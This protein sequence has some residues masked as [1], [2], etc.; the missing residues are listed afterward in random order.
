[1]LITLFLLAAVILA[2]SVV[3]RPRKTWERAIAALAGILMLAVIVAWGI[4][5]VVSNA[6][7]AA[8]LEN[9]PPHKDVVLRFEQ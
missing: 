2:A 7:A 6:K 4:D 8:R 9:P 1:M 3:R 5:Y